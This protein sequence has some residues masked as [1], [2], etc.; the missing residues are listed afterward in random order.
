MGKRNRNRLRMAV[1]DIVILFT[2]AVPAAAQQTAQRCAVSEQVGWLGI[3]GMECSNCTMS[4]DRMTFSTEPRITAVSAGSPAANALRAGDVILSVNG[5]LITTTEGG[6]KLANLKPGQRVTLVIR[7]DGEILTRTFDALPARCSATFGMTSVGAGARGQGGRFTPTPARP[8]APTATVYTPSGE[9]TA[10]VAGRFQMTRPWFGFSISCGECY[11]EMPRPMIEAQEPVIWRFRNP[12]EIYNV[13]P[14][15][16]AWRA[17]IRR[18]DRITHIDGI[19]ITREEAGKRFGSVRAGQTLSFRLVRDGDARNVSL[20]AEMRA[21]TAES[22]EA[23]RTARE[24]ITEMERQQRSERELIDK[25]KTDQG[26]VEREL[27]DRLRREQEEQTRNLT[28]L[29]RSLARAEVE[30]RAAGARER[31]R[32]VTPTMLSS[33]GG[34]AIRYSG[35]MGDVDVEVRGGSGVVVHETETETIITIGDTVVRLKKR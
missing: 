26:T 17:G 33:V 32:T 29:Q 19:E 5:S 11:I 8:Q 2:A 21:P 35:K 10:L 6:S 20:K 9:R 18:G 16:P 3:S 13:E 15:T 22:V 28:E 23:M 12:P 31:V 25:L 14:N 4:P 34:G 1:L 7:R 30:A 27:L 24:L